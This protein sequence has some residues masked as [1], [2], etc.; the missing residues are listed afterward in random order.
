MRS[1]RRQMLHTG[2]MLGSA[3]VVSLLRSQ[4]ATAQSPAQSTLQS[5]PQST[6]Q[7]IAQPSVNPVFQRYVRPNYLGTTFSQLQCRYIGLDYRAAFQEI[8]A[9]GLDRIRLCAYWNEIEPQPGVFD[10]S[11]LDWLLQEADRY[12][13]EVVLAVGMK[14]PRWTEFHFPQWVSDRYDTGAGEKALDLRS[15]AVAELA[16]KFVNEVVNHC[17]YA[18]AV[19]YWQIENEPFT[20]LEIAG[21]RFLSPE[22]VQREVSLVRS[23]LWQNQKIL[24]TNAIHLPKPKL[25]EDLPAFRES[26]M[27]ADAVGFN[28]YTKVPAGNSSRYL[29]P[30]SEFWDQ[31]QDWQQQLDHANKESWVAEAQAEPWEPQKLVALDKPHYPSASPRQMQRLVDTLARS[32]YSTVLLWGCEYWYWHKTQGRNLWLGTVKQMI[33][34]AKA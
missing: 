7:S 14:V 6:L 29:E 4:A 34:S 21:G 32:N 25:T 13:I 23:R 1:T 5:T 10:F 8:C 24:L 11:T 18:P 12:K 9:L 28:V 31:L 15:P 2:L 3:G 20:R 33:R 16:L 17:R 30:E 22:F 27:A 19:K 26:L